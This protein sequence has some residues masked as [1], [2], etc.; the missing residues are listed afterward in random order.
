MH[1][2]R[3]STHHLNQYHTQDH[4]YHPTKG[5]QSFGRQNL[6]LQWTGKTRISCRLGGVNWN[7]YDKSTCCFLN[8]SK[9]SYSSWDAWYYLGTKILKERHSGC[10]KSTRLWDSR[11]KFYFVFEIHPWLQDMWGLRNNGIRDIFNLHCFTSLRSSK[12]QRSRT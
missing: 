6:V 12:F 11:L 2:E 1:E 9:W 5:K 8:H 4:Q 10:Q 3:N 7:W